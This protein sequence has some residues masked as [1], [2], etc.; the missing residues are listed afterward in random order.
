MQ[1]IDS[2][3][4]IDLML[5]AENSNGNFYNPRLNTPNIIAAATNLSKK[6]SSNSLTMKFN[7]LK[8]HTPDNLMP[9]NKILQFY[10]RDNF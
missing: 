7:H 6:S 9:N 4:D 10:K 8:T 3:K 2:F 1:R 5:L